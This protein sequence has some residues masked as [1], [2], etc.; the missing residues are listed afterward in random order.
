MK[1]IIA[2][3]LSL[4]A[5]PASA[6]LFSDYKQAKPVLEIIKSD[7]IAIREYEGQDLLYVTTLLAYRCAISQIR[8]SYN[9]GPLSVWD[10]EPCYWDEASPNAQKLETHLPYAVAPL[11]SLQTITVDLLF[12]DGSNMSQS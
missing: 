2:L 4:M 11:G 6:D 3:C 8:F 12:E 10:S 5:T 1:R 9:N 7:W